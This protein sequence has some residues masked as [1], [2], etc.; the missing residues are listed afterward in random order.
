MS[1]REWEEFVERTPLASMRFLVLD[2]E[3]VTPKGTSPEPIEVAAVLWSLD[4]DVTGRL[5][6]TS[7]MRP[8][9]HTVVTNFDIAQTGITQRDVDSAESAELVLSEL[10]RKAAPFG[11]FFVTAQNARY[12]YAIIRRYADSCPILGSSPFLDTIALA[13]IVFPSLGS[14][15]L[16][17]LREEV[18]LAAIEGRHRALPDVDL[19]VDILSVLLSRWQEKHSSDSIGD[20]ISVAGLPDSLPSPEQES[21]F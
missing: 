6:F 14:Y 21:L 20:L 18:G 16:D 15:R 8:S 11:P 10:D 12:E 19:T 4:Q 17:S 5:R 3:T 13:R 1:V 2:F 9:A 7:L